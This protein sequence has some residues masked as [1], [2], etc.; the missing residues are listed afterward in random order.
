MRCSAL[1]GAGIDELWASI[2]ALGDA[3]QAE[4]A[5]T[6]RR[7]EQARAWL[8]GEI[9][10][11]LLDRV[12]AEPAVSELTRRLEDDAVA[13]RIPPPVAAEQ[14]LEVFFGQ[15]DPPAH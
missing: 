3:L 15:H 7:A 10:A 4:R 1:T 13:G 12:R 14:V 2:V 11:G 8:W 9:G 6:R 5:L